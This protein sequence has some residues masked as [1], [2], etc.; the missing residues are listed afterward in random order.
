MVLPSAVVR[1]MP[2]PL[3]FTFADRLRRSRKAAGLLAAG[4]SRAAGLDKNTVGLL[5]AGPGLP[6][7]STVEKLARALG[8]SPG[9]L[10]FGLGEPAAAPASAELLCRGL[11]ERARAVRAERGLSALGLAKAAG[12]TDGAVRSV[13]S[14]RQP[15]LATLEALAR[16]L[17]VSPAWLA[18]GEGPR[19]LPRRGAR[20]AAAPAA[21]TPAQ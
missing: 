3:H 17:R 15:S 5:E 12:L 1:G 11:A 16:A 8:L 2:N 10:A 7:L 14:G 18:F 21:P 9:W 13:E 6:K 19:E 20:P 4:L